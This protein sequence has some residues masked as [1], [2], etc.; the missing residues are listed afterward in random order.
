MQRSNSRFR[1]LC[2]LVFG[3]QIDVNDDIAARIGFIL[4]ISRHNI[5]FSFSFFWTL[6]LGGW[7]NSFLVA[8]AIAGVKTNGFAF[9]NDTFM[10]YLQKCRNNSFGIQHAIKGCS[11]KQTRQG[12]LQ[13]CF[14]FFIQ[15]CAWKM[16]RRWLE[17]KMLSELT[18][19]T[20]WPWCGG[21]SWLEGGWGGSSPL[22]RACNSWS[23]WRMCSR[24]WTCGWGS[25]DWTKTGP[26]S[27]GFTDGEN[28][29]KH[30]FHS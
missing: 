12:L 3:I 29:D 18:V 16:S 4:K 25:W 17:G 23:L 1:M 13:N 22:R 21:V 14:F 2:L 30:Y 7:E 10:G 28:C 26:S 27:T 6:V 20:I 11:W 5:F 24:K 15:K 19:K 9:Q 8:G